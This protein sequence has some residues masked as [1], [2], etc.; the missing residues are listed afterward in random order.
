MNM[1]LM[2]RLSLRIVALALKFALTVVIARTLGLA[3]VADYGLALAVSVV[4]SKLL[5]LGF[6]T[7]INRR[8]SLSQQSDSVNDACRLLL[9]FAGVY[10]AI[11]VII[12]LLQFGE[13]LHAFAQVRPAVL[14]GVIFVAF[15][16]H[17]ALETNSWIF[18]MHRSRF[19]AVLLFVRTGAWAAIA[20]LG[21][22]GGWVHTI[23][24]IFILWSGTN[25]LVVAV[26]VANL[27]SARRQSGSGPQAA[28]AA[29]RFGMRSLW[30]A[31]MPFFCATTLLSGL[32]Y[33]ERFVAS[34]VVTPA[35][36]G[37]YVFCWSISNAIQ[38]IAYA[39]VAVTAGPRLARASE[40]SSRDFRVTLRRSVFASIGLS[41]VGAVA[42]LGAW[43]LIFRIAHQPAGA[44][45]F[46][47]FAVLMASF[48][49]RSVADI[50]W[51]GAI[52]LRLGKPV[53][54][55]VLF[56]TLGTVPAGW[57]LISQLG[58]LGAACAHLLASMGIVASLVWLVSRAANGSLDEEKLEGVVHAS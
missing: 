15:S 12:A 45:A 32:Q 7:E 37:S 40:V 17:A 26:V 4:A 52:A 42:L 47:V 21:M 36:L 16:E 14:W 46:A 1:H 8:L 28:S 44:E 6:S 10:A 51:S 57:L 18:S 55:L 19:G 48:A 35:V 24:T 41:A 54:A 31:G 5:G 43:R 39:T 53:A 30:L 9:A 20:I 49:L 50:Y 27:L 56:V 23:D 11:A 22:I 25:V 13:E 34:A 38:T 2:T 33:A 3:A 58:I 29:S